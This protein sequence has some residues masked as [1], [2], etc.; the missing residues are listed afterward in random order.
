[1]SLPHGAWILSARIHRSCAPSP[2]SP[3]AS[4]TTRYDRTCRG[5]RLLVEMEHCNIPYSPKTHQ[6]S[7]VL[8]GHNGV[9]AEMV[10]S[11]LPVEI[12]YHLS[13]FEVPV[14]LTTLIWKSF[15]AHF[16]DKSF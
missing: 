15:G 5:T 11:V 8:A 3:P 1:M 9:A 14:C 12:H 4:H 13:S 7:Q 6:N 2:T 10:T 16:L